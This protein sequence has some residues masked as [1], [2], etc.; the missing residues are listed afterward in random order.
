QRTSPGE[1]PRS[2]AHLSRPGS[3]GNE[4]GPPHGVGRSVFDKV[5]LKK[6]VREG[7]P[8]C[9]SR[10]CAAWKKSGPGGRSHRG[11]AA[12]RRPHP[13]RPQERASS[14]GGTPKCHCARSRPLQM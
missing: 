13:I 3:I 1:S 4:E 11:T 12:A 10:P 9:L 6:H 7:R 2:R 8:E 5:L 14:V